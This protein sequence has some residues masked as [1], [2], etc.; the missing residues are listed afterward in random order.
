MSSRL[1]HCERVAVHRPRV[2]HGYWP[3]DLSASRRFGDV[4]LVSVELVELLILVVGRWGPI[5][6]NAVVHR[7]RDL[8]ERAVHDVLMLRL[9]VV[10]VGREGGRV[11]LDALA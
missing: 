9:G 4:E 3:R 1:P 7:V 10:L 5:E 11:G 2:P 8:I 6:G